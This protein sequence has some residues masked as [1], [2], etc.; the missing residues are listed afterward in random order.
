MPSDPVTGFEYPQAWTDR[1]QDQEGLRQVAEGL[2]VL[3]SSGRVLRRGFTTGTTASAACKAAILSLGREVHSVQID[4]SCGLRVNVPCAGMWGIGTCSKYSGDYLTDATSGAEFVCLAKSGDEGLRIK[5]GKGVGRLTRAF[6]G[7]SEGDAAVSRNASISI[8]RAAADALKDLGLEGADLDLT[9]RNGAERAKRTMN[10]KVGIVGGISILGSTGLVEPWDDH[11]E[12]S[13]MERIRQGGPVVLTTGRTGLRYSRLLFP[14]RE[15]VLV[16]VNMG[17][18]IKEANGNVVL[19][20]MP[21]LILKFLD[22]DI[23]EGTGCV[24]VDE[25]MMDERWK[26]RMESALHSAKTV[27][28]DLRVVLVGRDGKILGDSG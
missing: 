5:Y 24:T 10:E 27:R 2:A 3:T 9:I 18:A 1:C 4:L 7:M 14:E 20:G 12:T 8:E 22:P 6:N 13:V 15:S 16:G 23:L 28:E 11:V 17:Q 26:E 19:C 25:M 21:G